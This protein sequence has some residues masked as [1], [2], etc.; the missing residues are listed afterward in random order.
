[1]WCLGHREAGWSPCCVAKMSQKPNG[2]CTGCNSVN[3][4]GVLET[5]APRGGQGGAF[6]RPAETGVGLGVV[7]ARPRALSVRPLGISGL[8]SDWFQP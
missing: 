6:P 8:A 1:M 2:E 7:P 5:A 4:R 3:E